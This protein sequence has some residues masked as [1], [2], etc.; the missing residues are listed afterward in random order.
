[1]IERR[2]HIGGNCYDY[3]AEGIFVQPYGAHIFHTSINEVWEY[4][5]RFTKFNLFTH[6]VYATYKNDV[7]NFPINL[8]TINQFFRLNI[9]KNAAI[10]FLKQDEIDSDN[11]EDFAISQIGEDLYNAFVKEYTQKQWGVNPRLLHSDIIK[12]IPI[13]YNYYDS[14]FNDAYQGLPE[15]GYTNAFLSMTKNAII[16]L[17]VDYFKDR[18]FWNSQA[19]KIIYTGELDRYFDFMLGR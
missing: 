8:Q 7:Y 12:R 18:E 1:M 4:M 2:N 17:S 6:K 14:Y 10:E 3:N 5:N 13:R 19:H 11:F 9:S 15:N 16:K